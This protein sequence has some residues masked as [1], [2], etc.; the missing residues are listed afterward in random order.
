MVV[1]DL[2]WSLYLTSGGA[3]MMQK[4]MLG[5]EI[6]AKRRSYEKVR[7]FKIRPNKKI[8]LFAK[9]RPGEI[10]FSPTRRRKLSTFYFLK[11]T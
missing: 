3:C 7:F 6:D 2:D 9:I 4:S 5:T 1:I 10:L 8:S 11:F